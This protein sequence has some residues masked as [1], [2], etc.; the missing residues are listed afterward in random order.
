[1]K[2]VEGSVLVLSDEDISGFYCYRDRDGWDYRDSFQFQLRLQEVVIPP[3]S[4]ADVRFQLDED[5]YEDDTEVLQEIMEAV[6]EVL[7]EMNAF[8][9]EEA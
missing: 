5:G 6:H 1:M 2:V 8:A 4:I 7:A 9:S 3:R